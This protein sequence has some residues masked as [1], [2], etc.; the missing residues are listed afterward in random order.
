M[1]KVN[2]DTRNA[3]DLTE[4][5]RE[6]L[7]RHGLHEEGVFYN[8]L[9]FFLVFESLLFAAV[10]A[11]VTRND[12]QPLEV[13]TL[14]CVVGIIGSVVW[15]YAQANK[16]VLLKTLDD[17]IEEGCDEFR[18][19]LMLANKKRIFKIWSANAVLAHTFPL[20]FGIA[21]S[22]LLYYVRSHP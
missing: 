13:T 8:R 7:F 3:K 11:H 16:L 17:R 19:T 6:R 20:G 14:V 9:N 5:E 15:W 1:S 21:W 22:A 18:E 10:I 12:A 2:V 4:V